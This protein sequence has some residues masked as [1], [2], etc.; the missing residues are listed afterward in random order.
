VID[1]GDVGVY[2]GQFEIPYGVLLPRKEEASNLLVP[3]CVSSSHIGFCCLNME[4]QFMIMG[5][6]AGTASTLALKYG[7]A[8][9]DVNREELYQ[10]LI[11]EGQILSVPWVPRAAQDHD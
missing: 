5:H 7:V 8:V 6:S 10:T 4:P 1:E 2:P 3:V 9:Q 11:S